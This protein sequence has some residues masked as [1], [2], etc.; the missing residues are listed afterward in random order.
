MGEI[1]K[2]ATEQELVD[3]QATLDAQ[4]AKMQAFLNDAEAV[5]KVPM[6]EISLMNQQLGSMRYIS[7]ILGKRIALHN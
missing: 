5:Q 1:L 3:E 4:I 6:G 2:A 7:E